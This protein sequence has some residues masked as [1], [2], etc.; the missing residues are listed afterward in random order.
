MREQIHKI[1]EILEEMTEGRLGERFVEECQKRIWNEIGKHRIPF[2][3]ERRRE[4]KIKE[5][6][7][8]YYQRKKPYERNKEKAKKY[9]KKY[10]Q[11]HAEELKA[12]RR[13]KYKERK[14]NGDDGTCTISKADAPYAKEV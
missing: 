1:G 6:R 14:L 2:Y 4:E 8:N 7:K 11:D 10:Y 5:W 12:K 9:Q 13:E 3:N